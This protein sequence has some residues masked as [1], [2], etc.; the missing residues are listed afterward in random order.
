MLVFWV[1]DWPVRIS[2]DKHT[3]THKTKQKTIAFS[4]KEAKI[5]L[6]YFSQNSDNS[7]AFLRLNKHVSKY[8]PCSNEMV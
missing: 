2:Y 8:L 6:L 7:E 3:H 5:I 1:N 4:T